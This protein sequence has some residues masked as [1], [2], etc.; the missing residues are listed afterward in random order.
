MPLKKGFYFFVHYLR[1][2]FC[3]FVFFFYPGV[4]TRGI[5]V[6]GG[7]TGPPNSLL[8][9]HPPS[10]YT[11]GG[12]EFWVWGGSGVGFSFESL[13]AEAVCWFRGDLAALSALFAASTVWHRRW[14]FSVFALSGCLSRFGSHSLVVVGPLPRRSYVHPSARF[15]ATHREGSVSQFGSDWS[16]SAIRRKN[17]TASPGDRTRGASL[18]GQSRT[19]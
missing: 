4:E 15:G 10:L 16:R 2:C 7:A 5:V 3:F 19:N 8:T 14:F 6:L 17:S 9:S 18:F 1:F 11:I 13:F 12:S